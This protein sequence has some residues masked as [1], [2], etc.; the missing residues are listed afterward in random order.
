LA[1][2]TALGL[3]VTS[4]AAHAQVPRNALVGADCS[5]Q[6]STQRVEY[7]QDGVVEHRPDED[8]DYPFSEGDWPAQK[9]LYFTKTGTGG[10]VLDEPRLH[11]TI[12]RQGDDLQSAPLAAYP[13]GPQQSAAFD[14]ALTKA[15]PAGTASLVVT[16]QVGRR[17]FRLK[18]FTLPER[19]DYFDE[20]AGLDP[21]DEITAPLDQYWRVVRNFEARGG[22]VR[23]RFAYRFPATTIET[24]TPWDEREVEGTLVET[25]KWPAVSCGASRRLRL[26]RR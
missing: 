24:R 11:L 23:L 7:Y 10:G 9:I 6:A 19:A 12:K 3:A 18:R 15:T 26:T 13:F 20:D 22:K 25:I 14:Y 5:S 17:T 16:L 21:T 4:P 1:V 2:V 8:S